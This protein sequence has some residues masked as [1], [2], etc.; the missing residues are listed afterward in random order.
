MSGRPLLGR[1]KGSRIFQ[2]LSHP[3]LYS[4]NTLETF[5]LG[6]SERENHQS[7]LTVSLARNFR[8]STHSMG[9]AAW[10]DCARKTPALGGTPVRR[11]T[12]KEP[13]TGTG[14]AP[15][16]PS[17]TLHQ[18]RGQSSRPHAI[19]GAPTAQ[20]PTARSTYSV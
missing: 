20:I 18:D 1:I 19:F 14:C 7:V 11:R 17:D 16:H 5:A 13:E 2:Q 12:S 15:E 10:T 8:L 3:G 4:V 9:S 6:H